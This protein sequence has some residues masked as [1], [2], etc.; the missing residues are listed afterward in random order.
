VSELPKGI[1]AK[2]FFEQILKLQN[3]KAAIE[4]ELEALKTED[5]QKDAPIRFEEYREFVGELRELSAATTDPNVQAVICRKLIE[6]VEV[7]T[8][9]VTI[10]YHVGG[11]HYLSH[12]KEVSGVSQVRGLVEKSVRPLFVSRPLQK[13]FLSDGSNSL[14]NGSPRWRQNCGFFLHENP[15]DFTDSVSAT[16]ETRKFPPHQIRVRRAFG[17]ANSGADFFLQAD[18]CEVPYARRVTGG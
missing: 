10:H 3:A 17:K 8:T 5:L 14:K 2:V 11:N 15:N 1:D 4:R 7:S 18:R 9:G 6:K 12:F 16:R 13:Y